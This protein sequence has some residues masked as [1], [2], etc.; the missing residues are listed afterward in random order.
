MS[1]QCTNYCLLP[2][3]MYLCIPSSKIVT[4]WIAKRYVTNCI[5]WRRPL[6]KR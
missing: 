6:T 3:I 1:H 2:K 4:L 5:V